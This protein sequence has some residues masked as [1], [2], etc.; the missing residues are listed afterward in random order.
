MEFLVLSQLNWKIS[1][2]VPEDYLDYLVK[3]IENLEQN[4]VSNTRKNMK[5]PNPEHP[6]NNFSASD[7]NSIYSDFQAIINLSSKNIDIW[8]G[9]PPS[10]IAM[11]AFLII[12]QNRKFENLVNTDYFSTYY[13]IL[14]LL[15]DS[16][17]KRSFR[18]C[19][20][21]LSNLVKAYLEIQ[22]CNQFSADELKQPKSQSCSVS[23]VSTMSEN[24]Q[25]NN[26]DDDNCN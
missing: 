19:F 24:S 22:T 13:K 10:I 11:S 26:N 16:N 18:P 14:E 9:Y 5:T 23:P 17:M 3:N 15:D 6:N 8:F 4:K 25:N 21:A 1:E 2:P 7:R 20:I 12:I